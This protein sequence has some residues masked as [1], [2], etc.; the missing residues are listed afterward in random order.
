MIKR[1]TLLRLLVALMLTVFFS[2][3]GYF[4]YMGGIYRNYLDNFSVAILQK[5]PVKHRQ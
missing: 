3:L 4:T 2:G 1:F 5:L